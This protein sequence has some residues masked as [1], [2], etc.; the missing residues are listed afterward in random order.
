MSIA[1]IPPN[2]TP[3]EM[4]EIFK[5]VMEQTSPLEI[6]AKYGFTLPQIAAC[7]MTVAGALTSFAIEKASRANYFGMSLD[8][9]NK[10]IHYSIADIVKYHD[11]W[12][13]IMRNAKDELLERIAATT[14]NR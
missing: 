11:L 14:E 10:S 2:F 13:G 3:A 4:L 6:A 7:S 12:V 8:S 5:L 1:G 9:F